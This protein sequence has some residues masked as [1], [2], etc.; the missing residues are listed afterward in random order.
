MYHVSNGTDTLDFIKYA[1]VMP[2]PT[3]TGA[4][5]PLERQKIQA[6]IKDDRLAK[7]IIL[8]KV[9]M[10]VLSLILDDVSIAA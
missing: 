6:W 10:T 7:S 1:S 8:W 9:S 4:P 2:K 3:F 5:S